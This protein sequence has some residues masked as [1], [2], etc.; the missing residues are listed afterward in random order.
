M[1]RRTHL[2]SIGLFAASCLA[3]PVAHAQASPLPKTVTLVVPFAPGGGADQLAREFAQVLQARSPGSTIVVENRPG[4]NGAIATR[5]VAR[6]RPDGAT[7]LLGTSSTHALGPL[8]TPL[9]VDPVVDFSPVTVLADTANVL[10][11]SAQSPW[12]SLA[13]Y[14]AAARAQPVNYGTFGTGSSAHLYG[15]ILAKATGAKLEHV[16]YKGS[17]QAITELLGGHTQS[18]FLTT[19]AVEPMARSGQLRPLAVTGAA[20]SRVFP[21][22]PTFSEQGVKELDFNGWFGILA[23]K[24]LPAAQADHIASVAADMGRQEAFVRKMVGQ[25]YDWVGS[26]PAGLQAALARSIEVYRKVVAENRASL[27]N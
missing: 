27:G 13:D 12:R 8:L 2:L 18:V 14:L 4:A 5:H 10:A 7:L 1:Q 6:Q 3:M 16:P 19:S 15:L 26:T 25:G 9:D 24:G 20:R 17:G 22:V 23:P 21:D 11:V